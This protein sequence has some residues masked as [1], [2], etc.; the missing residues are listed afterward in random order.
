VAGVGVETTLTLFPRDE[1]GP[2]LEPGMTMK[3]DMS[4]SRAV[5]T[6]MGYRGHSTGVDTNTDEGDTPGAGAG[7]GIGS[8][9]NAR[10]AHFR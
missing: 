1:D 2:E 7:P 6:T 5:L 8:E 4:S 3:S 10:A 9:M